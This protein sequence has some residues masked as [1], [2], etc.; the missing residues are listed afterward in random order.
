M[1]D[2]TVLFA[3]FGIG[4]TMASAW[5]QIRRDCLTVESMVVPLRKYSNFF[6][7]IQGSVARMN[8]VYGETVATVTSPTPDYGGGFSRFVCYFGLAML[9]RY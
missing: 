2:E 9:C 5:L 7:H 3:V 4:Y 6:R 1:L 8:Q